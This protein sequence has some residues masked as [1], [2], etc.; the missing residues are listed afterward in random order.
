MLKIDNRGD[1]MKKRSEDIS[2]STCVNNGWIL[3]RKNWQLIAGLCIFLYL[4]TALRNWVLGENVPG[5]F[6]QEGDF[7]AANFAVSLLTQ[8]AA[9]L[10]QFAA[11][12]FLA[13]K[14]LLMLHDKENDF[15]SIHGL[16]RTKTAK[17]LKIWLIIELIII[18][19]NYIMGLVVV[20]LTDAVSQMSSGAML[21]FAFALMILPLLWGAAMLIMYFVSIYLICHVIDENDEDIVWDSLSMAK[22][23]FGK[24][25]KLFL[26]ILAFSAL[27][28]ILGLLPDEP[29]LAF[30]ANILIGILAGTITFFQAIF[31]TALYFNSPRSVL[32]YKAEE[33]E[34]PEEEP[35]EEPA[36][37]DE[38]ESE[39]EIGD[40][41]KIRVKPS[42]DFVDVGEFHCG[43]AC[44]RQSGLAG[45]G[46]WGYANKDGQLVLPYA[47][48][49]A[50]DFH[51]GIAVV[52]EGRSEYFIDTDGNR[53]IDVD[54]EQ[55]DRF[56]DGL[57]VVKIDKYDTFWAVIDR[58]GETRRVSYDD[59]YGFSEGLAVVRNGKK[60]LYINKELTPVIST[61]YDEIWS[62][63]DGLAMVEK[64]NKLGYIDINGAEVIPLIYDD[65][66]PFSEGL[67]AI[68]TIVNGKNRW[69]YIDKNGNEIIPS[70]FERADSFKQGRAAVCVDRK[71]GHIDTKGAFT[72]PPEYE[73]VGAFNNGFATVQDE[74]YGYVDI[75][76]SECVSLSYWNARPFSE[77]LAWVKAYNVWGILEI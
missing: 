39:E 43:L 69:G 58:E 10:L 11:V 35:E 68:M 14:S 53:I 65:A 12:T 75:N 76:G 9:S 18:I 70:A 23:T 52:K 45:K 40:I 20:P 72:T 2:F 77:N 63:C 27:I 36:L 21:F 34:E 48:N 64:D 67:A 42:L 13:A 54:Y 28:A 61:D 3:F 47:Y 8:L 15:T 57:A 46:K 38:T 74:T 41:L 49:E 33:D 51:D 1:R 19:P 29:P 5:Y 55:A 25:F 24:L 30:V 6:P 62:F 59:V 7:N 31:M 26:L 56:R 22:R 37:L 60:W 50:G 71:Y 44:V 17:L 66:L 32:S 4:V 73:S 16:L